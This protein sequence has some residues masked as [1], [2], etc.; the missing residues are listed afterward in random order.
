MTSQ[1]WPVEPSSRDVSGVRGSSDAY[2]AATSARIRRP[3]TAGRLMRR[4]WTINLT[5]FLLPA[6]AL[7]LLTTVALWPE[8]KRATEAARL[9]V[10]RMAAEVQSGQ[11]LDAR[12]HGVDEKGRPFTLTAATA[13]Q[14]DPERIDLTI[15]KGDITMENGTWLML[16]AKKGTFMQHANQLDL[17]QDVTLYRD[18]GTTLVTAS[19]SIDLKNGAAAGAE[20]VHAEGPFGTLDAEGGFTVVDKGAAIQF[21]GPAHVVLNGAS[22]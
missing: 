22:Q 16:N 1:P 14:V 13:R 4:R 9:A 2:L 10:G 18:D 15:P 19:A 11:L 7:A 6:A 12:Y 8:M 5:K 21:A 20:P 3:P 17:S